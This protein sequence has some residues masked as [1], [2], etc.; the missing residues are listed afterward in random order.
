MNVTSQWQGQHC[1]LKVEQEMAIHTAAAIK[2]ALFEPLAEA[3]TLTLDLSQVTELDTAGVQ[4]L[5]LLHRE[6]LRRKLTWK[7]LP[8][9]Q[10]VDE[11]I[12]LYQ[13]RPILCESNKDQGGE[14]L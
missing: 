1:T 9:S 4:L 13:L 5:L 2:D 12:S 10:A 14:R 6:V 3:T 8:V 7:L 11:V